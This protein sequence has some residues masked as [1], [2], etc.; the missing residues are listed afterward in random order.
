MAGGALG[1]VRTDLAAGM[2]PWDVLP[3]VITSVDFLKKEPVRARALRK[4]WD[5]IV[6]DEAHS[7]A[8]SGTPENPYR[9]QRT[10]LG[11]ALRD[12]CRGLLLL[13][14]TPHN[15]YSH[16]FR[17]LIELAEPTVATLHGARHVVERRIEAARIRRMKSQ[18]RRVLPDGRQEEVFPRRNVKGIPVI[19]QD[20]RERE[21]FRKVGS[22][23]SRTAKQAR[24][25]EEAELI[26]F[27][28]QIIKKRALSSRA[29]LEKTLEHRLEA[30][31]KEEA[32]EEPPDRSELRDLQADLPLGEAAAERTARRILRSAVPRE[33]QIRKSEIRA[34][35]GHG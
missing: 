18:I 15:G 2:N 21:L 26:G 29:A 11:W 6:V 3:R 34:L 23:C 9:T 13:T 33:E 17:S 31:R 10:R 24:E 35:H 19:M 30:L 12:A 5:F 8:E 32:R 1:E 20:D 4:R 16:S 25:T 27:A 22:Y 28:M 7:L 14:A